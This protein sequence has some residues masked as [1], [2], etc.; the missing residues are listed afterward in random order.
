MA[1]QTS[2]GS[3]SAGF[4]PV[5]VTGRSALGAPRI[6]GELLKLGLEVSQATV[7]KY[8]V[9]PTRPPVS[10]FYS[11]A[12]ILNDLRF[13][14]D[15]S[16]LCSNSAYDSCSPFSCPTRCIGPPNSIA[17]FEIERRKLVHRLGNLNQGA[18][19]LLVHAP[20]PHAQSLFIDHEG[21]GCLL[22]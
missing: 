8:L 15:E 16:R 22:A 18:I 17:S 14:A 7:S 1:W 5:D 3:R 6:H 11:S 2:G 12:L 21:L 20:Q 9:R 10:S 13:H 19:T 4:D